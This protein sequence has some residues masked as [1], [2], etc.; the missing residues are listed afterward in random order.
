M[1]TR[2]ALD[3]SARFPRVARALSKVVVGDAVVDGEVC[4]LDGAGVPR[5]ELIQQGR[6]D[7]AV[8]F[9][10]DLLR[11]DG[12]DLRTRPLRERRDLLRSLLSNAPPELR[13]SEEVPWPIH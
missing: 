4:V 6:D 8:L 10:F 7:E 9:A 2:N 11:L 12:E 1:W 13:L 3:L 5:F